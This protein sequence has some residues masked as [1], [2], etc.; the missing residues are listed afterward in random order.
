[1]SDTVGP[2]WHAFPSKSAR[3]FDPLGEFTEKLIEEDG[4]VA[5]LGEGGEDMDQVGYERAFRAVFEGLEGM[6]NLARFSR[7]PNVTV[8]PIAVYRR[9]PVL[10]LQ[11]ESR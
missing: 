3:P 8:Y 2:G 4:G 6:E 9:V 1:M 11:R 10:D 7:Y 5:A